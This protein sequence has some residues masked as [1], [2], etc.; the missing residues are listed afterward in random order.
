[1]GCFLTLAVTTAVPVAT[2]WKVTAAESAW[3][4]GDGA[5]ESLYA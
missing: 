5:E 2:T 4:M 1:M 3:K